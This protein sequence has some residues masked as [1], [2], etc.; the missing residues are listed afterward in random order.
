M[1]AIVEINIPSDYINDYKKWQFVGGLYYLEDGAW[2]HLKDIECEL[3]PTVEAIPVE[4]IKNKKVDF[5][6]KYYPFNY[7]RGVQEGYNDCIDYLIDE[8]EKMKEIKL[9]KRFPHIKVE[10]VTSIFQEGYIKGFE[11][12]R[13]GAIPI[14]F[15][16]RKAFENPSLSRNL[17]YRLIIDEWEKEN[18][19]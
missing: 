6:N 2:T 1:K 4:W 8:W 16:K 18:E 9:E 13:K 19:T 5:Q 7:T 12:G 10:D 14:E 3:K 15:I 11:N 17:F